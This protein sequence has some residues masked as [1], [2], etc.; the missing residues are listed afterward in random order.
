MVKI[1]A[2]VGDLTKQSDCEAIVN[3][4]N[5]SMLK[6]SGVCGAIHRA[7][8]REL[9]EYGRPL[10]PLSL[11]QAVIT[12]AFNLP[13]KV[14]I[15]VCAPKYHFDADPP[16]NLA[17]CISNALKLAEANEVKRIAFP[18]IATG[19]C[20]YPMNDAIDVFI[21]AASKFL[22]SEVL[23]EVRFVFA[24]AVDAILMSER[25]LKSN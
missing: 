10:G 2:V 6:G 20:G 16:A 9:E 4:A 25:L 1:T 21:D 17:L 5:P 24:S 19:V 7:A 23:E 8:G 18:A 3:S 22:N 11:R 15:H 14:V 13:N 12:P